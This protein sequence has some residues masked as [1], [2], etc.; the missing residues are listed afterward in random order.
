MT[1]QAFPH[2]FSPIRI[3]ARTAPNRV[4]RLPT[5]TNTGANGMATP[6]TTAF[7]AAVARGGSGIIVTESMRAHASNGARG[8]AMLLHEP[9]IVPTLVP[10]AAAMRSHGALAIAQIN[11]T[12]RQHHAD[13]PPTVWG[14][15]AIACPHSGGVPHEL[16]VAE[17]A[18]I[19]R[20]F[21]T[22]ANHAREAG[23]DG[24]EIHGAQGHLIQS[25]V[26]PFSNRRS[27][28]YGGSAE[29][30]LRFLREIVDAV[31]TAVGRETIVGLRMGVEEFWPGALTIADSE[32]HARA[33]AAWG[34]F[35]Y[36]SLAQGSFN[37]LDTHLPDA[38]YGEL[39]FADLHARIRAVAGGIPVIVSTRIQTPQQAEALLAGG[40]TDLVG[41]C[42]ALIAD[43]AWPDKARTGRADDI[44]RCISTSQCWGW[45]IGPRKLGC[46]INPEAGNEIELPPLAR[47]KTIRKV[48]VVGGGPGGLEAARVAADLG[49]RV[50]LFEKEPELGGRLR[51][52][53][54]YQPYHEASFALDYLVRQAGKRD[55]D[56]RLGVEATADAIQ[57]EAPDAVIV[58]TGATANVPALA[59]DGSVAVRLYET[60]V[61]ATVR[62]RVVVMDEDGYY[63]A[64]CVTEALARAG[65]EVIYVTRFLQPLRELPEVSRIST[66]RELDKLGVTIRDNTFVDRAERGGIVLR[67]YYNTAREERLAD[68]M[69]VAWVGLRR[70]NDAL[71]LALKAQGVRN[72]S[73]IG[74][75]YAPRRL[76]EA[77]AEGHRAAR[78]IS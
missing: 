26:S 45:I 68:V 72:V 51:G 1:A 35:D 20:G 62:G 56:C 44:R 58:A 27:D 76:V 21:A 6:R 59:G 41:L 39:P 46:S 64:A 66:L 17:I 8:T 74:D 24:V 63:W 47:A 65:A 42:R 9:E 33:I 38:H 30:R 37:T 4:M 23:F 73:V 55:I 77:I 3:G 5:T 54:R 70:A 40:K 28:A 7:Y 57:A 29:N 49:H 53:Q 32:A 61:P 19:V 2:L 11:H 36:F 34:V 78:G 50:V 43:P 25:F 31:R 71:A 52:T 22:A 12:G 48:V 67:H 75:A 14:P 13:N 69:Q 15:S 60:D 16:S 18:D 10:M